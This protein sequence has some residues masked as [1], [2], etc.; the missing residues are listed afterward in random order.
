VKSF[1]R[2]GR[3]RFVIKIKKGEMPMARRVRKIALDIG[4]TSFVENYRIRAYHGVLR[5]AREH[6]SWRLLFNVRSFS[7]TLKFR[8]YEDLLE[9]GA[10]GMIFLDSDPWVL[11]RIRDLGLP[12][13]SLT[14]VP[15]G[16]DFPS[17]LSDDFEVGRIAGDHFIERGFRYFGFTG[18]DRNLW[19]RQRLAGFRERLALHGYDCEVFSYDPDATDNTDADLKIARAM[20]HWVQKIPKPVGILGENDTRALHILEACQSLELEIPN[21]VAILGVDNN[22]MICESRLPSLSSVEQNTELVGYE[23]AALLDRLLS[24][25]KLTERQVVV[26]PKGIVT[27]M[28]SDILAVD[29]QAVAKGLLYIRDNLGEQ[30]GISDVVRASGVSRSNLEHRFRDRL[31]RSINTEIR[32]RRLAK[33]RNLLLDTMLSLE[34]IARLSGFRR[35]TYFSNIFQDEYGLSPGAWR[36]KNRSLP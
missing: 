27:R 29:D 35:A 19:A 5:Y 33:A 8:K 24:N 31:H 13:V 25:R 10:D 4:V 9:L 21:A 16:Y 30:F 28:S 14:N 17:S 12:A 7:L 22:Q 20:R 1:F 15:E 23:A 2:D 6:T 34:E 36:R 26:P 32:Q 11:D 18:S 3:F